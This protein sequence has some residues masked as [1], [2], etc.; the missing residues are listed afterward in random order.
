MELAPEVL[1]TIKMTEF[2]ALVT[3]APDG[4]PH[5]VGGWNCLPVSS[6]RLL[7]SGERYV[8]T[9]KNLARDSR[10]WLLVASREGG[11]GYRLS[12]RAEVSSDAAD[13]QLIKKY[14]PRCGFALAITVESC[15]DLVYWRP[16]SPPEVTK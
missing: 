11:S 7:L 8:Q 3:I 5:L 6:N 16:S 14:W 4:S 15:E 1:K 2:T 12:G 10:V 13:S 9:R